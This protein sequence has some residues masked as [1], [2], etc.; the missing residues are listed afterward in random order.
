MKVRLWKIRLV[1]I[2]LLI[3][4]SHQEHE[5]N[6]ENK[7]DKEDKDEP[8]SVENL[9]D[10]E[11]PED[12]EEEEDPHVINFQA[13]TDP[14]SRK[15]L[16][17][18]ESVPEKTIEEKEIEAEKAIIPN[19]SLD[20]SGNA[21]YS[22]LDSSKLDIKDIDGLDDDIMNYL[23]SIKYDILLNLKTSISTTAI[24]HSY[25]I[26]RNIS[27]IKDNYFI[28]KPILRERVSRIRDVTSFAVEYAKEATKEKLKQLITA[29]DVELDEYNKKILIAL[30]ERLDKKAEKLWEATYNDLDRLIKNLE[31]AY[32]DQHATPANKLSHM[33]EYSLKLAVFEKEVVDDITNQMKGLIALVTDNPKYHHLTKRYTGSLPL[34]ASIS[35]TKTVIISLGLLL[36]NY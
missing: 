23:L 16:L 4:L 15:V 21:T 11:T 27:H 36:F 22:P 2:L 13:K 18:K 9:D 20:E 29:Q 10:S 30:L 34:K 19:V 12:Q 3:S 8:G 14:L 35:I 17:I 24:D 32:Q 7:E 5:G 6:H 31:H 33:I 26:Y 28:N 1:C 25:L